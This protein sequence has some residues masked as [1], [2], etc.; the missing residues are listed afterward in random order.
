MNTYEMSILPYWIGH[1]AYA[2]ETYYIARSQA[3]YAFTESGSAVQVA[4][5]QDYSITGIV[6]IENCAYISVNFAGKVYK[7]DLSSGRTSTLVSGINYPRDIAVSSADRHIGGFIGYNCYGD[8]INCYW[9]IETSGQDTSAGGAG[10]T[11]TEMQ[12]ASTF[13]EAGWD[14]VDET[15][16]GTEDIWWILEGHDYPRLW[17]ELTRE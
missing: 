13:L 8:V 10:K 17:W 14:F 2:N 11:K 4:E 1:I 9:D 7:V 12:T 6:V 16:N 5:I 3:V 15:A